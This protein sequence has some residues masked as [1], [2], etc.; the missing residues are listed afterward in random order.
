MRLVLLFCTVVLAPSLLDAQERPGWIGVSVN[1]VTASDDTDTRTSVVVT[2]VQPGSPA[3]RAGIRAGDTLVEINDMPT[4]DALRN[5]GEGLRLAVGDSVHIVLRRSDRQHEYRIAATERPRVV[6]RPRPRPPVGPDTDSIVGSIVRA[7]DSMRVRLAEQRERLRSEARPASPARPP[8]F[9]GDP[10]D[11]DAR[12]EASDGFSPLAPYLLGR[13]RVA[14]AE[15]IDIQP[16]L[17]RYFSVDG[18][19]LVVDVPAGTPA[20]AA[21]LRAGDVIIR[22]GDNAIGTVDDLRAAV[23]RAPRPESI[24]LIR[25]GENLR[26]TLPR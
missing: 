17:A 22:V 26:V 1:I 25:H 14:G 5:L 7:M 8:R 6:P 16:D 23:S 24:A 2:G 4:A 20:A 15:V 21:D 3:A 12:L 19:V 11:A 18:G 10:L 13:N 9:E